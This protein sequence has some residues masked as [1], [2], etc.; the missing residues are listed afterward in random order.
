MRDRRQTD[1]VLAVRADFASHAEWRRLLGEL[2]RSSRLADV[3]VR[4]LTTRQADLA[5][6]YSGTPEAV[7]AALAAIGLDVETDDAP[8][9]VRFAAE[10]E[11]P[12]ATEP[13]PEAPVAAPPPVTPIVD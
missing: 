13:A 12:P 11:P 7:R 10:S 6:A 9:R 8:W 4:R 1:G 3:T 5:L 2:L